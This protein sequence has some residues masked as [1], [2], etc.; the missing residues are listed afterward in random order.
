MEKIVTVKHGIRG[1]NMLLFFRVILVILIAI[2]IFALLVIGSELK[3]S[4]SNL[5]FQSL[6]NNSELKFSGKVGLYFLGKIKLFSIKINN[7]KTQDLLNNNFIKKKIEEM[8]ATNDY[9]KK[10]QRKMAVELIK[11]LKKWIRFDT[12]RLQICIDTES[13]MLTS[14]LVGIVS[15]VI[16]NLIRNNIKSI[17]TNR[18]RIRN[19]YLIK[20]KQ[21]K[22]NFKIYPVYKN[23]NYIYLKVNSIISIKVVHIINMLK[24]MGG[25]KNE[26]TSY[27][28]LNANCY[29][30]H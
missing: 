7:E 17:D 23:Q 28:R 21:D 29:G 6:E 26:R 20:H 15:T 27:R 2:I 5:E 11:Q 12:L 16:P 8:K 13:V 4:I 9:H 18:S 10:L 25:I 19:R 3:L 22:Y 1:F 24:A 14:Y 30:E